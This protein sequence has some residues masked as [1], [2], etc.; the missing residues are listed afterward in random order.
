MLYTLKHL[1]V[2]TPRRGPRGTYLPG[3]CFPALRPLHGPCSRGAAPGLQ[4]TRPARATLY[5][6]DVQAPVSTQVSSCVHRPLTAQATSP[7]WK[8]RA[9]MLLAAGT[10][11][12]SHLDLAPMSHSTSALGQWATALCRRASRDSLQDRGH[13]HPSQGHPPDTRH[14][15]PRRG[16]A[17]KTVAAPKFDA[18]ND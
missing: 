10:S 15:Q 2:V 8:A 6:G 14:T 16:C 1:P 4:C 18:V 3:G 5:V 7:T 12:A 13:G 9:R 17:R 11:P